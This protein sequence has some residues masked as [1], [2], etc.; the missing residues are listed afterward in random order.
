MNLSGNS[1]DSLKRAFITMSVATM[2]TIFAAHNALAVE[3]VSVNPANKPQVPQ[4]SEIKI[5]DIDGKVLY[6]AKK[7][8][9][10]EEAI[11][12]AYNA[13]ADLSRANFSGLTLKHLQMSFHRWAKLSGADFSRC[14]LIDCNI[15]ADFHGAK[16]TD[17]TLVEV[18]LD[19]NFM[20]TDF[21]RVNKDFTG[22]T[23][24]FHHVRKYYLADDEIRKKAEIRHKESV[25]IKDISG[26]ILY[27]ASP[28]LTLSEAVNE[29]CMNSADLTNADFRNS[30]FSNA[31]FVGQSS[32]KKLRLSGADFSNSYFVDSKFEN[33]EL[34]DTKLTDSA[35][36]HCHWD[37]SRFQSSFF[38][39]VAA[40]RESGAQLYLRGYMSHS[41]FS[42][43]N[44][45]GLYIGGINLSNAKFVRANLRWAT[46]ADPVLNNADFTGA[47]MNDATIIGATLM[48]TKFKHCDLSK[49]RFYG[50]LGRNFAT[51]P[52]ARRRTFDDIRAHKN[53]SAPNGI[54]QIRSTDNKVLF[55]CKARSMEEALSQAC[56]KHVD[57][58]KAD[59]SFFQTDRPIVFS[60]MNLYKA[61]FTGAKIPNVRFTNCNL[62]GATFLNT[63]MFP[64]LMKFPSDTIESALMK[65]CDLRGATLEGVDCKT[66][67]FAD[68]N[69][70]GV[71]INSSQMN[72]TL[73]ANCNIDKAKI[74]STKFT[75][76]RFDDSELRDASFKACTLSSY[77]FDLV[78]EFHFTLDDV[79]WLDIIKKRDGTIEYVTPEGPPDWERWERPKVARTS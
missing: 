7:A 46:F 55:A 76:C 59:L 69:L 58:P 44:L 43:A 29:A 50:C 53:D 36:H 9:T 71:N 74:V 56:A 68:C 72:R 60:Q 38:S 23:L 21:R 14:K 47:L 12:E 20:D 25:V 5:L 6:Q 18:N 51:T 22:E 28:G 42:D 39:E 33:V 10:L 32:D 41:D 64:M 77:S 35:F 34:K 48:G 54:V 75:G 24:N 61:D 66:R 79:N 70:N 78:H 31:K 62:V 15:S 67:I 16:F 37:E 57:L 17:A 3:A 73:F 40:R 63:N 19:G 11:L 2:L 30:Y 52:T 13:D 49:V 65:N 26:K 45:V 8:H 27:T 4:V 1:R